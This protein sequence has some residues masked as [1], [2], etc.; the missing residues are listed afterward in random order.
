MTTETIIKVP[1][2]GGFKDVAII[3][4][5]VKPGDV[6]KPEESLI[7]LESDKA[8]ME[9]PAPQ[10]GTVKELKV[11]VGDKVGQGSV[12][13][14]LI[15]DEG[16]STPAAVL[17]PPLPSPSAPVAETPA[18]PPPLPAGEGR[19]E[20]RP[21]QQAVV[22]PESEGTKKAHA[23]PSVRRFA[24]ELGADVGKIRGSGPKGR[25]LKDDVQN[26]IKS[27]LEVA[28]K[29]GG[30]LGFNFPELPAVDFAQYG[31]IE[32]SA[33]SRIK[34]L[35]AANLHRNWVTI[36]HV[37]LNEEADIT[38]LEAFRASLKDEAARQNTKVT[39]LPFLIRAVVATLKA[40][41][42]FNASISSDGEQMILKRYYHIGVAVD[43][44]DGL[45][46]PP[47]KDAD[48]KGIYQLAKEL[49]E[50]GEKARSKKLRT[51]E[52]MGGTFTISSLG[53]IGS[54]G[55]TPIINA[56]EVAILG[57]GKAQTKP[58]YLNGNW[59]PRLMLPLSLS[60]DHRVI[61][62]AEAARFCT[63]LARALGDVRRLL[64]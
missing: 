13:L 50:L 7:T 5:L 28:E 49:A 38:E 44:P 56:P 16:G 55:F 6:I 30:S 59:E 62:G 10:G 1:D 18:V 54:T 35:T 41:P 3:E 17:E 48:G 19:G 42:Q 58:Q 40:Y 63:F 39:L 33:L 47:L 60:F 32:T 2:I 31:P 22:L 27:R 52:L 24:R 11:K 45:V 20:G 51:P 36:P 57:V 12:I 61:D 64:L 8:A 29:G 26:Y 46:V 9:I 15:V 37:T 34:K 14:T 4:V 53:G 25:I 23:S 21:Q 43:T